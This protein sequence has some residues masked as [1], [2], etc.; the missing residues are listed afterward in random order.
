[1]NKKLLR[2]FLANDDEDKVS[3]E[4]VNDAHYDLEDSLVLNKLLPD[5]PLLQT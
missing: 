3:K 5:L 1:M 4:S 2:P